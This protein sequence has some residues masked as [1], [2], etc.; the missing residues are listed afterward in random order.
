MSRVNLQ[1]HETINNLI[2]LIILN[3]S[4]HNS[5]KSYKTHQN[6]IILIKRSHIRK[7]RSRRLHLRIKEVTNKTRPISKTI[8]EATNQ[9]KHIKIIT[10]LEMKKYIPCRSFFWYGREDSCELIPAWDR[11]DVMKILQRVF[12]E[13][14]HSISVFFMEVIAL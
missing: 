2:K 7:V 6:L 4:I 5:D 14:R 8:K 12:P 3:T 1:L 9:T 13:M 11:K 10:T